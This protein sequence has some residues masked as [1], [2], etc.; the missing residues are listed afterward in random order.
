MELIQQLMKQLGISEEQA[1]GGL[2]AVLNVAKAKL[3][4]DFSQVSS[5]VPGAED[6]MKGAPN[7]PEAGASEP[8]GGGLMGM[9]GGMLGVKGLGDLAGLY[10]A[11]TKLGIDAATIGKFIQTILAFVESQGG[12][13]VKT[14]LEKVLTQ[15]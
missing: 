11:F 15:K 8:A 4:S 1:K 9:I 12:G 3:G 2:G 7:A 14:L 6:V 13:A 10:A 5:L